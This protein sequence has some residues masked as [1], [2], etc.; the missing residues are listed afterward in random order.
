MKN[1]ESG[2]LYA[3]RDGDGNLDLVE[4]Q[5]GVDVVIRLRTDIHGD[6]YPEIKR[7]ERFKLVPEPPATEGCLQDLN[8][9]DGEYAKDG[10]G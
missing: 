6:L 2:F 10:E 4:F 7:G 9:T 1:G 3:V 5:N 8:P